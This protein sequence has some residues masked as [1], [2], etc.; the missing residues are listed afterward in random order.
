VSY[1]WRKGGVDLS[2]G[3]RISGVTTSALAITGL[4]EADQDTYS[5]RVYNGVS[6]DAVPTAT[7]TVVTPP[8]ITTQPV[9][10]LANQGQLATF[11]VALISDP[12]YSVL[13]QWNKS[14]TNI[15]GAT[16]PNLSVSTSAQTVGGYAVHIDN[17]PNSVD[18]NTA[19]LGLRTTDPGQGSSQGTVGMPGFGQ[20]GNN[21]AGGGSGFELPRKGNTAGDQVDNSQSNN[22]VNELEST[23]ANRNGAGHGARLIPGRDQDRF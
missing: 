5:V 17:G 9:S 23:V 7:L 22:T 3:P 8:Y 12:D 4:T 15:A 18:S 10:T 13:Y 21:M 11:Q 2:N 16:G 6:P 20:N 19:T 1:Q 14:G